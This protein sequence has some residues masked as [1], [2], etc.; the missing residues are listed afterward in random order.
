MALLNALNDAVLLIDGTGALLYANLAA[1]QF[2]QASASYLLHQRL[3]DLLP[4]DSPL[5]SLIDQVMSQSS[6]VSEYGV[7]LGDAAHR[8]RISSICRWRRSPSI[9]ARR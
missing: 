9:R 8:R 3:G 6:V 2:F 7:T 1:E 5:F 4:A